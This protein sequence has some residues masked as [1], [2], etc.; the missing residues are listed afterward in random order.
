M[1]LLDL[2]LPLP[3]FAFNT[4]QPLFPNAPCAS[5]TGLREHPGLHPS[6]QKNSR[7]LPLFQISPLATN[8][9]PLSLLESALTK[10]R[11]VGHTPSESC[12]LQPFT[13]DRLKMGGKTGRRCRRRR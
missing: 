9:S 10:N 5:R 11:G 4:L 3:P 7:S 6:S 1:F 8:R 2:F 12:G 13:V